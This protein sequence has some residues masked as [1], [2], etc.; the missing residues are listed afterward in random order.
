MALFL[1]RFANRHA[2]LPHG[3]ISGKVEMPFDESYTIE[4]RVSSLKC[5]KERTFCSMFLPC[6]H[7]SGLYT[8]KGAVNLLGGRVIDKRYRAGKA[9]ANW[10]AGGDVSVQQETIIDRA[11]KSKLILESIDVWLLSQPSLVK[12]RKRS[13][14]CL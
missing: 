7:S 12:P 9:L 5:P 2:N 8:L 6:L 1:G 4:T 3:F 11:V 10:R 14:C 13:L